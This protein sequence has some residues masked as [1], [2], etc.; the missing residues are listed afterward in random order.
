MLRLGPSGRRIGVVVKFAFLGR[1]G[2]VLACRY[3]QIRDHQLKPILGD[4]NSPKYTY[5][6]FTYF[7]PHSRYSLY[8]W[9]PMPGVVSICIYTTTGMVAT[10]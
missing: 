7:G 2:L 10:R 8:T 3:S 9:I 4:P 5:C 6:L 1:F